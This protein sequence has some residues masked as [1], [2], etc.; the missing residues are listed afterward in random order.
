MLQA[1]KEP[2]LPL[3]LVFWI[4]LGFFWW[5]GYL[6]V[7]VC[8]C[9][10]TAFVVAFDIV[11]LFCLKYLFMGELVV[12]RIFLGGSTYQQHA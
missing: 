10:C 11:V 1:K 2:D 5:G 7:Y 8:V 12:P 4:Y 3:G 9:V 6:Y